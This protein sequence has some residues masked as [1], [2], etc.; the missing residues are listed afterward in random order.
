MERWLV[1]RKPFLFINGT[2]FVNDY[3]SNNISHL[4][5]NNNIYQDNYQSCAINARS[6]KRFLVFIP[7]GTIEAFG[8]DLANSTIIM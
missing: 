8:V 1:I 2:E 6:I 7:L 3:L 5:N 4:N